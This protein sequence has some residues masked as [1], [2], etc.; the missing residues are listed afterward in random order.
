MH[1]SDK[2]SCYSPS[3]ELCCIY[4]ASVIKHVLN[5]TDLSPQTH[6]RSCIRWNASSKTLRL[7]EASDSPK[8]SSPVQNMSL[9]QL[10]NKY[11]IDMVETIFSFTCFGQSCPAFWLPC[12]F[13]IWKCMQWWEI[14][15][16]TVILNHNLKHM[17]NMWAC[18]NVMAS[19][20][21]LCIVY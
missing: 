13:N 10:C 7:E 6:W 5:K 9:P 8:W 11:S 3:S 15:A 4:L 20:N 1:R 21:N 12:N 18:H 14:A 2:T 17:H 19:P 16:A